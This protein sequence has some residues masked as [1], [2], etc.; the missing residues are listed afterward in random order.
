M[1]CLR[2]VGRRNAYVPILEAELP[3]ELWFSSF[4]NSCDRS[5]L[6]VT[7]PRGVS[8]GG[9][10]RVTAAA[11][12]AGP[13]VAD[14]FGF[15]SSV[16]SWERFRPLQRGHEGVGDSKLPHRVPPALSSRHVRTWRYG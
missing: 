16:L 11:G 12:G 14:G 1:G 8:R 7:S 15:T 10:V 9:A 4:R 6:C 5:T 3:G 2:R 13:A